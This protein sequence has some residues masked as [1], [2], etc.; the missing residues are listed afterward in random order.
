MLSSIF[1]GDTIFLE[2]R[3]LELFHVD[4]F[5]EQLLPWLL[6]EKFTTANFALVNENEGNGT[7]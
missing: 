6:S 1:A 5:L 7:K 3:D 4:A 2:F